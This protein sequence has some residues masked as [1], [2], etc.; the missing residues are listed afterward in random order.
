MKS[1][2]I[3]PSFR[4]FIAPQRTSR[5]T[6]ARP[7]SAHRD[8]KESAGLSIPPYPV[9][10]FPMIKVFCRQFPHLFVR[11][12]TSS[13]QNSVHFPWSSVVFDQNSVHFPWSS[14]VFAQ[15]SVHIPW[16]SLVFAQNSVH[17]P[18]NSLVFAQNSVHFPWNSLVFARN[19]V[20]FPF[21]EV[22]FARN[23]VK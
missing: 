23:S 1:P 7:N 22:H 19:S 21:S 13:A 16:N 17:F 12:H 10:R 11:H 8:F 18:W 3:P 9:G 14:L 15:S 4:A 5:A 2:S 6:S 20:H